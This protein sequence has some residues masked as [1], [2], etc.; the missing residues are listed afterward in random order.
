MDTPLELSFHNMESSAALKAAV[1]EHVAKL[2][3]FHGHIIGCR[4]VIEMPHRSRRMGRNIPDVHIVVR[5]PGKDLVV[6]REMA[7]AG[8]KKSATDAYALLDNA[9]AVAQG[10]LKDYRRIVQGEV[11][12]KSGGPRGAGGESDPG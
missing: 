10:Q 5:V 12:Y 7:H 6:S 9:F 11:K 1:S 4:V 3:Q 8:E 2:E